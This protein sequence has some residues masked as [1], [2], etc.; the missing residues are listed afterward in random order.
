MP[1]K[2][3]QRAIINGQKYFINQKKKERKARKESERQERWNKWKTQNNVVVIN[4]NKVRITLTLSK[5]NV[6]VKN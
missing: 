1:F 5:V 6:P 4:P 3:I 2:L